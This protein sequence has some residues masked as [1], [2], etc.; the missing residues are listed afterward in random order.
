MWRIFKPGEH[1]RKKKTTSFSKRSNL[2]SWEGL[3]TSTGFHTKWCWLWYFCVTVNYLPRWDQTLTPWRTFGC[4]ATWLRCHAFSTSSENSEL[5][6]SNKV[7]M[8]LSVQSKVDSN[9]QY[10]MKSKTCKIQTS[11]WFEEIFVIS[12]DTDPQIS[13]VSWNISSF[14]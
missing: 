3:N 6:R 5:T 7:K 13:S 4:L 2:C 14:F 10:L 8:L 11:V 1:S 12:A 9:I